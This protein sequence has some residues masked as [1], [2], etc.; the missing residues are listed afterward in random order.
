[1]GA[2]AALM[3]AGLELPGDVRGVIAAGAWAVPEEQLK[4]A[5]S[6]NALLPPGPALWLLNL[7][8]SLF[9]GFGLRDANAPAALEETAYPVLILHGGADTAANSGSAASGLATD[10]AAPVYSGA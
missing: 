1:M 7:H 3:A 6:R 9:F 2:T 5:L 8:T 10:A 4:R